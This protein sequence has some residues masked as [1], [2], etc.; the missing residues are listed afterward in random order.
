MISNFIE[1]E[2]T[3]WENAKFPKNT[4]VPHVNKLDQFFRGN[5]REV[6]KD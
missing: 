6:W 2:L 3:R 1:A 4:V 5:I